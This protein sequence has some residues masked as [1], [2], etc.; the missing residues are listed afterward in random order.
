MILYSEDEK[1]EMIMD[2]YLNPR[3]RVDKFDDPN[4]E[5][6][7][8]HSSSCVDEINLY[9]N[10]KNNDI[11]VVAQG[12]AIFL[13]SVEIFIEKLSEIG[14]GNKNKLIDAYTRLVEKKSVSEDEKKLL[15]KLNI[16]ENVSKHLN[17]KECALM[18][19]KLIKTV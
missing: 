6:Y 19:A 8:L 17:R 16:Y 12:C 2:Y 13:S 3:I 5:K 1:R 15:G 9:I 4:Y 10:K 7:Y 18:I 11:K 14:F